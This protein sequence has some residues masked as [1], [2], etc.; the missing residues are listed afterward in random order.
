[1]NRKAV[2]ITIRYIALILGLIGITITEQFR[3]DL[4]FFVLFLV[5]VINNQLRFFTF[6]DNKAFFV[7]SIIIELIL[8]IVISNNY[9]GI[10]FLFSFCVLLDLT[11]NQKSILITLTIVSVIIF[12]L[13]Y[14]E[15]NNVLVTLPSILSIIALASLGSFIRDE[16]ERKVEAQMFYDKLRISKESLK[17]AKEELE[18]YASTIEELTLLR[19]RNR[20]SREIHDSVGHSLSTMIIQL[21]AIERVSKVDGNSGS[22]MAGTLLEFAKESL[23][24]VRTAV[25]ALKPREFEKYQG[26][27]AIEEMIKNFIKL[28]EVEVRLTLSKEKYELNQDQSFIL[29]R[30]VQEC[31]TN[32]VKHGKATLVNISIT[33]H[34][35]SIY[36]RLKDNGAGCEN[37]V[38]NIGLKSIRERVEAV[39]GSSSYSSFQAQGFEVNVILPKIESLGIRK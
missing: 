11:I 36:M 23:Q 18:N 6:L 1:M 9:N 32:A 7:I 26:V 20:I 28:T 5:Y 30:V 8:A 15:L 39:G 13:I 38:E 17:K 27:L 4:L 22:E 12:V 34:D 19:E 14:E 37:I 31:L 10:L 24:Q 33:F 3:V 29:Y 16:R 2:L 25:N 35:N 21:G